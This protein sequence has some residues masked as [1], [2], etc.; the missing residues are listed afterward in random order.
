[1]PNTKCLHLERFVLFIYAKLTNKQNKKN[2]ATINRILV[3]ASFAEMN[4][5]FM[6]KK[7][8]KKNYAEIDV[9]KIKSDVNNA[10]DYNDY[11][12]I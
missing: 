3:F 6:K 10:P 1:M 5:F 9:K 8:E 11:H 7:F 4:I 12:V 2:V